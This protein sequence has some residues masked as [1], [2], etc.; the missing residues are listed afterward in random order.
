MIKTWLTLIILIF[1]I[2]HTWG[3]I[4]RY[5]EYKKIRD[6][7]PDTVYILFDL[8]SNEK[9]FRGGTIDSD[10]AKVYRGGSS[11]SYGVYRF[12]IRAELFIFDPKKYKHQVVPCNIKDLK[13]IRYLTEKDIDVLTQGIYYLGKG[14]MFKE[15]YL[16][17]K[18]EKGCM[19]YEV[20]WQAYL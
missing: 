9:F 11:D 8:T 16:I 6:T 3:Q 1:I 2:P 20:Y 5:E 17:E 19:K 14:T 4:L 7:Y 12:W 13:G 10:S 15:V 18:S